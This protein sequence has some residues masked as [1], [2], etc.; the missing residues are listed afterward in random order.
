M[1]RIG[2]DSSQVVSPILK[3]ERVTKRFGGVYAINDISLDIFK[4][5]VLA[6]VG[7]NGAGKSTLIKI[8]SGAYRPDEGSIY[9]NGNRVHFTSPMDARRVGIETIYQ[10]LAI[11]DNLDISS[12]IFMGR[13]IKNKGFLG[14][15]GL[16]NIKE[17]KQCASELLKNFNVSV[18]SIDKLVQNLS[19]GQRQIVSLSRAI[20]FN[21]QIIL[22]DEPTAALGVA[23]TQKVYE[24]INEVR[25]KDIA[26][27]IVSHNINEVFNIADRFAIL[28]TGKLVAVTKK[29]ETTVDEIVSMI[30][31]GKVNDNLAV[32]NSKK[33]S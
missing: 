12:N 9:F 21:A 31:S 6:L 20:Y 32:K 1:N 15:F 22:M 24:F 10:N 23:E 16:L 7:D 13:E 4:G 19:G 25:K 5:D 14:Y 29:E 8:V 17:M 11:M 3:I 27:V 2:L 18:G 33:T 30:I 26:V 28:K